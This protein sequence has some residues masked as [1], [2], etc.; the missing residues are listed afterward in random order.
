MYR[1]QQSVVSYNDLLSFYTGTKNKRRQ[2]RV[3]LNLLKDSR[4]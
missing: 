3:D 2:P 1:D 4:K